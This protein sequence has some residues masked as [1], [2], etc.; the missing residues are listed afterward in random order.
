VII[1]HK[2]AAK[3][4]D[5]VYLAHSLISG[6]MYRIEILSSRNVGVS[7]QGFMNYTYYANKRLVQQ[8]KSLVLVG[9]SPYSYTL[10][11]PTNARLSQWALV[12]N[13]MV[14]GKHPLT[15]RY[16]DLGVQR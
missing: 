5:T 10:K 2:S 11:P 8:T 15:V 9:K 3:G 1:A 14:T 6:H 13:A 16:R 12:V 7:A 4:S